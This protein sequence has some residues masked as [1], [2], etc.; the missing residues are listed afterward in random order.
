MRYEK[1]VYQTAVNEQVRFRII[2]LL[3]DS[4]THRRDRY[5]CETKKIIYGL[6]NARKI[7]VSRS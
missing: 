7:I 2:K 5:A 6:C 4:L 3:I 1:R